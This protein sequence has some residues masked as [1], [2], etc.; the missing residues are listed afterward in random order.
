LDIF[1]KCV[2]LPWNS[3]INSSSPVCRVLLLITEVQKLQ[4]YSNGERE[5]ELSGG[6]QSEVSSDLRPQKITFL[7]SPFPF[8]KTTKYVCA[9]NRTHVIYSYCVLLLGTD[10]DSVPAWTS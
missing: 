10:T 4:K 7:L 5:K 9:I 8:P 2:R 1:K 3:S 6:Q